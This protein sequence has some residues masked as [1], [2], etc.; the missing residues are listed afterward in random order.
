M[1]ALERKA[2]FVRTSNQ[3]NF[4][5]NR[6]CLEADSFAVKQEVAQLHICPS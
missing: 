2:K 4:K 3:R 6:L 5:P 1:L